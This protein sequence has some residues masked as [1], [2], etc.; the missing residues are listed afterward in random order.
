MKTE[1]SL[2]INL[3]DAT[4]SFRLV[5]EIG[6]TTRTLYEGSF[7]VR[8]VLDSGRELAAGRAY[9]QLLGPNPQHATDRES[10]L[11]FAL[12]QLQLRVIKAPLWWEAPPGQDV[13]GAILDD[14]ILLKVL[15]M[16][17]MADEQYRK[18]ISEESKELF[19]NLKTRIETLEKAEREE[20]VKNKK[21][22]DL[23]DEN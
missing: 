15:D 7:T 14:N 9:R 1:D 21:D 12:S 10:N 13:R 20:S 11:A 17:I 19:Q 8:A 23:T 5:G 4:A 16:A 2:S 18:Q 3:A 22:Q 6:L